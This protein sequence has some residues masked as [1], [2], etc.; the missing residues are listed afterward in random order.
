MRKYIQYS[1]SGFKIF[2]ISHFT[3]I[4]G[5]GVYCTMAEISNTHKGRQEKGTYVTNT[6]LHGLN[7]GII[8]LFSS[9]LVEILLQQIMH[10]GQKQMMLFANNVG[11]IIDQGRNCNIVMLLISEG[12]AD[13]QILQAMAL[14]LLKR[15]RCELMEILTKLLTR[16]IIDNEPV[17]FFSEDKWQAVLLLTRGYINFETQTN[18]TIQIIVPTDNHTPAILVRNLPYTFNDELYYFFYKNEFAGAIFQKHKQLRMKKAFRSDFEMYSGGV[19]RNFIK[20]ILNNNPK[21]QL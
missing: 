16:K 4:Y 7:R 9:S 20:K 21:I 13:E 8:D 14:L 19:F 15:E 6:N 3:H 12:E 17:L 5:N 11:T 10:N 18:G 2:D 1:I